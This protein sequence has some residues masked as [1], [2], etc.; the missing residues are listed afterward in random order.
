MLIEHHFRLEHSFGFFLNSFLVGFRFSSTRFSSTCHTVRSNANFCNRWTRCRLQL[1]KMYTQNSGPNKIQIFWC[2][3]I[4]ST[5]DYGYKATNVLSI[6]SKSYEKENKELMR[7]S[8]PECNANL[9][10][11][12]LRSLAALIDWMIGHVISLVCLC[13]VLEAHYKIFLAF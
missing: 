6:D 5:D 13:H 4:F 1:F 2:R 12:P 7:P 10:S 9:C 3:R 11:R 8:I